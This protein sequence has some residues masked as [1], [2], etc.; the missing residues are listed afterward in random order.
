MNVAE[1][2][3]YTRNKLLKINASHEAKLIM[4]SVMNISLEELIINN[5]LKLNQDQVD[6]LIY[7]LAQ[8]LCGKP[9]QYILGRWSF[10]GIPMAVAKNVLIPRPET[11]LL[12]EH[13]IEYCEKNNYNDI[14][15][16]CTGS[17]C[18]AISMAHFLDVSVVASDISPYA[19]SLAN[20][21]VLENQL[22]DKI[23]VVESDMFSNINQTF[24]LI[25]SNPPYI[26]SDEIPTLMDEVKNNEPL[27]A[28]DGGKDGLDFY[29]I[30]AADASKYLNPN[31]SV[32]LEVGDKQSK[33]VAQLLDAAGFSEIE[34][35]KDY[36]GIERIVKG[37]I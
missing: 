21:N 15:D 8:R 10:M 37:T 22:Q 20:Q 13:A 2:T 6:K 17:G 5:G 36:S 34:I 14:L 1:A 19:L 29:W 25:I 4:Q 32:I 7:L 12:V 30:I 3:A 16:L 26:I 31:G 11:E 27:L 9:L 24:D 28:L 23:K 18:I 35:F 33:S